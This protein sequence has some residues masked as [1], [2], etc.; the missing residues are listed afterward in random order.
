M[1]KKWLRVVLVVRCSLAIS[2]SGRGATRG[3]G[4]GRGAKVVVVPH[5]STTTLHTTQPH[6][7]TVVAVGVGEVVCC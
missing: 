7:F 4:H 1:L 2:W 6:M 5:P 3:G